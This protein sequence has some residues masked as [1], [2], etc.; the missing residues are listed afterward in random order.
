M[1]PEMQ[2]QALA[3][4]PIAAALS[5]VYACHAHGPADD[6]WP[7][8]FWGHIVAGAVGISFAMA[9]MVHRAE[10]AATLAQQVERRLLGLEHV[11]DAAEAP[12]PDAREWALRAAARW[13]S[14]VLR[15]VARGQPAVRAVAEAPLRAASDAG[16]AASMASEQELNGFDQYGHNGHRAHSNWIHNALR[17]VSPHDQPSA[18]GLARMGTVPEHVPYHGQALV[19]RA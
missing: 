8:V 2:L 12:P 9:T 4:V 5:I 10:A 18:R 7:Y 14:E 15:R 17:S 3:A 13:G 19:P 1:H 11:Q 16:S 6:P